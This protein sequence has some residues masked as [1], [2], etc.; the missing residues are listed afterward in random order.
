[1]ELREIANDI[2]RDSYGVNF[3]DWPKEWI[4]EDGTKML[5]VLEMKQS[6][7]IKPK[8]YMFANQFIS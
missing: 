7:H 1:M 3:L 6:V 5:D 4:D 8:N 2:M